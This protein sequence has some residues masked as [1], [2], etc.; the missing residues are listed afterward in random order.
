MRNALKTYKQSLKYGF[1]C[2]WVWLSI[3]FVG[4]IFSYLL[5]APIIS[6]LESIL[7]QSSAFKVLAESFDVN[8]IMDMLHDHGEALGLWLSL[9][10][11]ILA[12]Q[13]FFQ[14]LVVGG[15]VNLF[16]TGSKSIAGFFE[17]GIRHLVSNIIISTVFI[18][19]L[20]ITILILFLFFS[21]GDI[22]I[23]NL[24]TECLLI[25]RA[26]LM[27]II[28]LLSLVLLG[29]FRDLSRAYMVIIEEKNVLQNMLQSLKRFFKPNFLWIGLL[30]FLMLLLL[31]A[32]Y[33]FL[34]ASFDTG[35]GAIPILIL[36]QVFVWLK[37]MLKMARLG[38]IYKTADF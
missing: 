29:M 24:E 23:L 20:A 25:H 5:Y 32:G 10:L 38:S 14:N 7:G 6:S 12:L 18:I 27:G 28:L 19:L 4:L 3:Y 8:I 1:S 26:Y 16:K 9:M 34:M 21:R 2:Y 22:H 11:L 13:L 15:I 31:F 33:Y 37:L 17:A 30:D 35:S 36:T